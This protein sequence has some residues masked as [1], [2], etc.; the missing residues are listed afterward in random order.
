MRLRTRIL[1]SYLLVIA[2]GGS[3]TYLVVRLLAPRLFDDRMHLGPGAGQS[4]G[5]G[6]GSGGSVRDAFRSA[7]NV[8][9]LIGLAGSLLAA[10]AL[11]VWAGLRLVRPLS[12]LRPATRRVAAGDYAAQVLPPPVPE[13]AE[14]AEDGNVLAAALAAIETRRTR[15]L[16]EVAH[17]MRTPLTALD[18]YVEG[19]IDGVFE[20]DERTLGALTDELRRLHRLADDLAQLSRAEERRL[21]IRPGPC[22]LTQI[23]RHAADRL[24]QQFKDA[25]VTLT[26][27]A[28][29]AL[30]V[31]VDG[32]RVEQVLAN[33]LGNALAA[34]PAGGTVSVEVGGTNGAAAVT[35][36]DTGVGLAKDDL[37]RIF[38]RFYRAGSARG[39]AGSGIGLT[40]ARAIARAHGGDVTAASGG[41]GRGSRFTLT[42]PLP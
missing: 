42:L 36:S 3:V 41:P 18:G 23:A 14:L 27:S 7:V 33:L 21:E 8:A 30:P 35:I 26:V 37:E 12:Q 19:L 17:E 29:Q 39:A 40:I 9:L 13:L 32:G 1:L 34:T 5:A 2:V 38:E 20:A 10:G 28:P 11:A 22:D 15:L 16:G 4:M 31:T 25:G 6:M 24:A